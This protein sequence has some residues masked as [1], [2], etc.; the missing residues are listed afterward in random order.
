MSEQS[1]QS[2]RE[3]A[4]QMKYFGI[5]RKDCEFVRLEKVFRKL[6]TPKPEFISQETDPLPRLQYFPD[7]I[8]DLILSKKYLKKQCEEHLHQ[9]RNFP[10]R[11]NDVRQEIRT[12]IRRHAA[13]LKWF[14]SLT[15]RLQTGEEKNHFSTALDTDRVQSLVNYFRQHE[16]DPFFLSTMLLTKEYTTE[17]G[18]R[19]EL[20]DKPEGI[21]YY[22]FWYAVYAAYEDFVLAPQCYRQF[23]RYNHLEKMMRHM[24]L[25]EKKS[26]K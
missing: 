2:K 12:R 1:E 14:D 19:R 18:T 3:K 23:F 25:K 13:I 21:H 16:N 15:E 22:Y 26:K 17:L 7:Y 9:E 20:E 24:E 8:S 4:E 6:L 10:K 5:Y 11:Y